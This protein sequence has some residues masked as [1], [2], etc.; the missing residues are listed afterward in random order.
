MTWM[1]ITASS[2]DDAEP[3]R[4]FEGREA[5]LAVRDQMNGIRRRTRMPWIGE[6]G[7]DR[8][9]IEEPVAYRGIRA[10]R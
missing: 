1:K 10:H 9:A 7:R 2:V 6:H 5:F 4:A 8:I 3:D